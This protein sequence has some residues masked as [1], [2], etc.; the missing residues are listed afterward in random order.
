MRICKARRKVT[1]TRYSN[2]T[3]HI[4]SKHSVE[5]NLSIK[6]FAEGSTHSAS[7]S[8]VNFF[9]F[10]ASLAIERLDWNGSPC[11]TT[12]LNCNKQTHSKTCEIRIYICE[13]IDK[14]L[15]ALIQESRIKNI[16]STIAKICFSFWWL[17]KLWYSLWTSL[18]YISMFKFARISSSTIAF[19]PFENETSQGVQN[20]K[21][22]FNFVLGVYN[23]TLDNV[24]AIIGDNCFTNLSL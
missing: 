5:Y 13:Y 4:E 6:E 17:D 10:K 3:Q 22:F 11:I 8:N 2:F 23:K 16:Y 19:S 1:G 21:E 15:V 20:H 24:C 7:V 14:G 12:F 18:W 9:C